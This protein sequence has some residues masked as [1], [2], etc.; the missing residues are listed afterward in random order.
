[1]SNVLCYLKGI[2]N[3]EIHHGG[4]FIVQQDNPRAGVPNWWQHT[5]E[6][7]EFPDDIGSIKA[8]FDVPFIQHYREEYYKPD[9]RPEDLWCKFSKVLYILTFV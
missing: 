4:N 9:L 8:M 5:N 6:D 2:D 1:M 3:E 7:E